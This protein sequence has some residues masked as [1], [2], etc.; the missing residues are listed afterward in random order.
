M[1][2]R[3]RNYFIVKFKQHIDPYSWGSGYITDFFRFERPA[4]IYWRCINY[5]PYAL[6][7]VPKELSNRFVKIANQ[8]NGVDRVIPYTEAKERDWD[9][10]QK[11][12]RLPEN[13]Y[14]VKRKIQK[15]M[16]QDL[17]IDWEVN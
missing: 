14:W 7:S 9:M 13:D 10:W 15:C 1:D 12:L 8:I 17:F 6:V 4:K 3:Y 5:E 11:I 16:Q 2:R